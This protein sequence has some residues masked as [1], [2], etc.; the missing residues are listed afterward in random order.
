M[1]SNEQRF[2]SLLSAIAHG[3]QEI[4]LNGLITY[5]NPKYHKMLGYEPGEL[6]GMTIFELI[7]DIEEREQL[8]KYLTTVIAEQPD[9]TPYY[10]NS[11]RKDGSPL[12]T[13]IDWSYLRD[14]DGELTGLVSI[15]ADISEQ[16][17][18]EEELHK[19]RDLARH[20]LDAA[21]FMMVGLDTDGTISVI[22][23]KA[24]NVLGYKR[25]RLLG[26]NWFETCIP[27][28]YRE[29]VTHA[30]RQLLSGDI[31]AI[32]HENPVLTAS[33][34]QRLTAWH[35]TLQYDNDGRLCGTLSSGE[36]ITEKARAR[37]EKTRLYDEIRKAQK[38]EA[39]GRLTSGIAH[40]FNNILASILGYADLALDAVTQLGEEEIARYLNEVIME[41]EK[42]RDLITQMLAF[43]R[44]HPSENVA[45]NP[46]PLVKELAKVVQSSLPQSIELSIATDADIPKIHIDPTQLHQAI[47]NVCI[48]ARDALDQRCGNITIGVNGVSCYQAKCSACHE[49]FDGEYVEISVAD[50]GEG[51]EPYMLDHIFEPFFSTRESSKNS[52][53]GLATVHGIMHEHDGHILVDSILDYGTTVR[54]LLPIAHSQPGTGSAGHT[55][56][57]QTRLGHGARLLIVEDDESIAGLQSELLQSRGFRTEVYSDV[58]QALARFKQEPDRFDCVVVDQAMPSLSGIEFSQKLLKLRP[59]LPIILCTTNDKAGSAADLT[60]LGIQGWLRK[61]FSSEQLIDLI[62]SL[63]KTK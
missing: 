28:E 41:G 50:D 61:P 15:V 18:L 14:D 38:M 51:I 36:D 60:Q 25:E 12:P 21:Q 22:N 47:L 62:F 29:E 31:K 3:V 56:P 17:A 43:S 55:R 32:E 57:R 8:G 48:N 4:D 34:E 35:N 58:Y 54:L 46:A 7:H 24:C 11:R 42:A 63:L 44:G 10:T 27:E 33:G 45:L 2:N 19:E 9:P 13:R 16:L 39:L 6:I 1:T 40:D 26:R 53:M 5:S 23:C 49:N 37:E 30:F 52:G 59:A 20:Y